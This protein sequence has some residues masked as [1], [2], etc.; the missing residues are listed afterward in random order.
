[1]TGDFIR[2]SSA[3]TAIKY[4]HMINTV[5]FLKL[6]KASKMTIYFKNQVPM[7]KNDNGLSFYL[8]S[9]SEMAILGSQVNEMVMAYLTPDSNF[10]T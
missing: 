7:T 5:L 6:S 3:S 10:S 4:T 9:G 1:M 8:T 2:S